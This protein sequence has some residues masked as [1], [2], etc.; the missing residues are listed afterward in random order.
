MTFVENSRG[1]ELLS[2][3]RTSD[4]RLQLEESIRGEKIVETKKQRPRN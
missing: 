2:A 4:S 1:T 3:E